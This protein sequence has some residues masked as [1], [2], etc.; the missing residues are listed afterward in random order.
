[1]NIIIMMIIIFCTVPYGRRYQHVLALC[2][3][4]TG[5][6]LKRLT[7]RI[8]VSDVCVCM[9]YVCKVIGFEDGFDR[10]LIYM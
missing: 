6:I 7:L 3:L 4:F 1:M 8:F 5:V 2:T 9:F 10:G